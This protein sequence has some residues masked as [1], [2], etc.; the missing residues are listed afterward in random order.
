[1]F[2]FSFFW[3]LDERI[4]REESVVIL[5]I[6]LNHVM[7]KITTPESP[8]FLLVVSSMIGKVMRKQNMH[9]KQQHVI[10]F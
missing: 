3:L 5:L 10:L 8:A 1:M 2:F 6:R 7:M 9:I 4:P